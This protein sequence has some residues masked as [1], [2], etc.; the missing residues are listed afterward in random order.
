MLISCPNFLLSPR[1][2]K[3]RGRYVSIHTMTFLLFLL[4]LRRWIPRAQ[5]SRQ[6]QAQDSYH[7]KGREHPEEGEN[8]TVPSG[9]IGPSP[10]GLE[11]AF[12]GG[13]NLISF[14]EGGCRGAFK[15]RLERR[16]MYSTFISSDQMVLQLSRN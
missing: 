4:P 14:G 5:V 10:R 13:V 12:L 6:T 15:A 3:P 11:F 16:W 1:R 9:C 7:D 8:R 2:R